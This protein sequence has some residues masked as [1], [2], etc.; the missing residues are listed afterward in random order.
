M[1]Q[2]IGVCEW[3]CVFCLFGKSGHLVFVV[4]VILTLTCFCCIGI[5]TMVRRYPPNFE[6]YRK[7]LF[8]YSRILHRDICTFTLVFSQGNKSR[9]GKGAQMK[10]QMLQGVGKLA[11]C[12]L[13]N[14]NDCLDLGWRVRLAKQETLTLSGHLVSPLVCRGPWMSTVVLFCW[15]HSDSA[16]VL[17]YFTFLSHLFPLPC[18]ADSTVSCK[19]F[20]SSVIMPFPGV[21]WLWHFL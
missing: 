13:V 21:L 10:A 19:G 16:S 2:S 1:H 4:S 18:G 11:V 6:R 20:D 7:Y 8:G 12:K 5:W 14:L 9:A 17:S 3:P 15:Y